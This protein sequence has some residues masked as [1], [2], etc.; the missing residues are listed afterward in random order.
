LGVIYRGAQGLFDF[1]PEP[2]VETLEAGNPIRAIIDQ[3]LDELA[4]PQPGTRALARALMQQCLVLLLRRQ[5]DSG[6]W[7]VAW[8]AALDDRRLGRA[9]TA[10]FECPEAPHTLARLAAIAGM[11]RSAFAE[12]F[13][14]S[15]GRGPI[16]LVREVRL[17][18]AARLLHSTDRPIKALAASVG[19]NSRSYFSRAFKEQFGLSPAG[20]RAARAA[21]DVRAL[22]NTRP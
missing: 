6:E 13:A 15:F 8:L 3:L 4:A 9:V 14:A 16:D 2:I 17:R 1:L 12:H 10:I 5:C 7:R 11:S 20:Y 18:R 21:A 22:V 19:Y